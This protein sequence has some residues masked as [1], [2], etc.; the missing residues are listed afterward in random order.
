MD[1]EHSSEAERLDAEGFAAFKAGDTDAARSL[2]AESLDLARAARDP[3]ATARALAGLMR[4]ALR[5]EDFAG[6][7][8][9]TEQGEKLARASG[10]ESLMRFPLHMKAEG[11]RMEGRLGEAR[12]AYEASIA[13]NRSLGNETMV[14][15]ESLNLAWVEIEDG[16]HDEA[17]RLVESH[18]Q[19][20]DDQDAY[21]AAFVLLTR[22][23][24][25]LERGDPAGAALLGEAEDRIRSAGLVWDPAEEGAYRSTLALIDEVPEPS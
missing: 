21:M 23:R 1:D 9:L 10:D 25:G 5:T 15:V 24:I 2:H 11:L 3:V 20:T 8:V 12:E 7:A 22:A 6:L 4:V 17:A 16:H 18:G 14:A 19:P 13:L